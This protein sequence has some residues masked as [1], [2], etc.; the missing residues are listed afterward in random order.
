MIAL[1]SVWLPS[2]SQLICEFGVFH[3][4]NGYVG[5]VAKASGG[6]GHEARVGEGKDDPPHQLD[7]AEQPLEWRWTG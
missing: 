3:L 5:S 6:D 4:R 2:W 7:V 1:P